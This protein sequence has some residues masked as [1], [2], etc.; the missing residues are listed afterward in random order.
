MLL[1]TLVEDTAQV[2][3]CIQIRTTGR[4]GLSFG[5]PKKLFFA[6]KLNPRRCFLPPSTRLSVDLAR[7]LD[8]ADQLVHFLNI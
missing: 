3:P 4:R 6:T 2:T 5:L 8:V 7:V 1:K